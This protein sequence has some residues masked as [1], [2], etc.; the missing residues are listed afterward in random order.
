MRN[1]FSSLELADRNDR[2]GKLAKTGCDSIDNWREKF[3]KKKGGG[4][5]ESKNAAVL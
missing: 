2:P 1:R 5:L 3:K 4:S